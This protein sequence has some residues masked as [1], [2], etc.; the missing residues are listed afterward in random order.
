LIVGST[1]TDTA[2]SEI[3]YGKLN[4]NDASSTRDLSLMDMTNVGIDHTATANAWK[5]DSCVNSTDSGCAT[6]WY[7]SDFTSTTNYYNTDE[8][9]AANMSVPITVPNNGSI[10]RTEVVNVLNNG[11]TGFSAYTADRHRDYSGEPLG[12]AAVQQGG[13]WPA[14]NSTL[15]N[16]DDYFADVSAFNPVTN[17]STINPNDQIDTLNGLGNIRIAGTSGQQT[18][19]YTTYWDFGMETIRY[20]LSGTTI[21]TA[22][23][24]AATK[25]ITMTTL[26][27]TVIN[28]AFAAIVGTGIYVWFDHTRLRTVGGSSSSA[29]PVTDTNHFRAVM[30]E[31][32]GGSNVISLSATNGQK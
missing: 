30:T 9:D 25:A 1:N 10:T 6:S 22:A 19:P 5:I 18:T 2:K 20:V 15:F 32:I 23:V 27:K 3:S 11:D 13:G 21:T 8:F 16:G 31:I 14:D 24:V 7:G 29:E 12:Y 28:A 17:G 26:Q 4:A